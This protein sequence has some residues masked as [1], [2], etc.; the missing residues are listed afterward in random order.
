MICNNN[1]NKANLYYNKC[2][3]VILLL[4]TLIYVILLY[5]ISISVKLRKN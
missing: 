3:G 5:N 2:F 4:H 1:N